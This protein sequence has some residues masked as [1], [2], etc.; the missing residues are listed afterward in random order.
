MLP[1]FFFYGFFAAC[2]GLLLQI[3]FLAGF[4][5]EINVLNPS[6]LFLLIAALIEETV[7]LGFL[8]QAKR[9]FGDESLRFAALLLFGIG[10][11]IL[12]ILFALFLQSGDT[13]PIILLAANS[14]FHIITVCLLGLALKRF[15]PANPLLW[16][17]LLGITLIHGLYNLL[18]LNT[19]S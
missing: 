18:R 14:L 4:G 12:E 7:K 13:P 3:F 16:A 11:A 15:S 5:S 9:R 2:A 19:L 1:L 8:L 17:I 10:F 6:S